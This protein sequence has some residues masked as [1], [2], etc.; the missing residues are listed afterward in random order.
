[1][2]MDWPQMTVGDAAASPSADPPAGTADGEDATGPLRRC[3]VTREVLP[4]ERLIRFAV[5]PDDRIVPDV[6]GKLP[7]RGLWVKAD[8]SA[9]QAAVA[10]NVFSKAARRPVEVPGDLSDRTA[11]MLRRRCLDLIGLAR[12]AGQVVTGFE[13]VRA[14]LLRRN[15]G[16]L[17]AASDGAADGKRKMKG[18]AEGAGSMALFTSAELSSALGRE[19]VVHAALMSG[20]LAE[21]LIAESKRLACLCGTSEENDRKAND[22]H[23]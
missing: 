6:E 9:L 4:K 13:R 8:R 1:M 19:N 21:L 17:L 15:A 16:V 14:E 11:A 10:K 3:I 23:E 7:G 22:D 5:D 2:M 12:R 20:R 18:P